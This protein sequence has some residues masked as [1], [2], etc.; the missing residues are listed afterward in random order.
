MRRVNT[1][2]T[3]VVYYGHDL[4]AHFEAEW[5][6]GYDRAIAFDRIRPIR[7]WGRVEALNR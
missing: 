4:A 2:A 3:D 7:F 5:G 1:S 6:A